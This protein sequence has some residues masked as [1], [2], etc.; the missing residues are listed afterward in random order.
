VELNIINPK[1]KTTETQKADL[2]NKSVS[3]KIYSK[4]KEESVSISSNDI[5]KLQSM[6]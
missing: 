1:A 6:I 4:F 3:K 5:K 2:N